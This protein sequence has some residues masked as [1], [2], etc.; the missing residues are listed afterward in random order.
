[1]FSFEKVER[2][3]IGSSQEQAEALFGRP[4]KVFREKLSGEITW[5]YIEGAQ[6]LHRTQ[7]LGLTFSG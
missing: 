4:T 7:R 6:G 1:M 3:L 5:V 2:L